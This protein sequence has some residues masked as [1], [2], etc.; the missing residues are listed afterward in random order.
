MGGPSN[1][2]GLKAPDDFLAHYGIKGMK[3]G[4]RRKR[5][6]DGRVKGS[7]GRDADGRLQ[8]GQPRAKSFDANQADKLKKKRISEMTN[9]EIKQLS[10]RLRIEQELKQLKAK[11][12]N[13][14]KS[15][16]ERVKEIASVGKTLNDV[17]TV[18]NG[19]LGKAVRDAVKTA[20][21]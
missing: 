11:D 16:Q 6:S 17:Y 14:L 2:G 20:M 15:G 8:P 7:G 19:P 12:S 9:S 13:K 18:V 10:E 4:V 5:G 21:K 1:R 3:W